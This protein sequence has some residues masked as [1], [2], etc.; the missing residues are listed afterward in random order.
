MRLPVTGD[1]TDERGARTAIGVIWTELE[2]PASGSRM[3]HEG[4]QV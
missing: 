2:G 1:Y 3:D 4:D